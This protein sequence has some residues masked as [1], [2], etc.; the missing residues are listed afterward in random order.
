M[1]YSSTRNGCGD[2][3][4]YTDSVAERIRYLAEYLLLHVT[5]GTDIEEIDHPKL[6]ESEV[7]DRC[8]AAAYQIEHN[9]KAIP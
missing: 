1:K 2:I 4:R 6:G 5:A 8:D 9:A 7:Q 3:N